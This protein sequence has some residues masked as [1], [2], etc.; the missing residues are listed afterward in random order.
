MISFDGENNDVDGLKILRVMKRK[1][2]KAISTLLL[3]FTLI[4]IN[5]CIA[6]RGNKKVDIGKDKEWKP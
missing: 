3:T 1:G 2:N 5:A 4:L 6:K